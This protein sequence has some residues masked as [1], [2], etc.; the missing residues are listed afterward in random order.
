MFIGTEPDKEGITKE[1]TE[2]VRKHKV[3]MENIL[4]MTADLVAHMMLYIPAF[5]SPR[6]FLSR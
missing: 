6:L 4:A 1:V 3:I 2:E 5:L